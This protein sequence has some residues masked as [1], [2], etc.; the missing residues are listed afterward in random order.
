MTLFQLRPGNLNASYQNVYQHNNENLKERGFIMK[1]KTFI[2]LFAGVILILMFLTAC[3]GGG[4]ET[5]FNANN[6]GSI[7]IKKSEP[8][9]FAKE[10]FNSEL[11]LANHIRIR[12][13]AFHGDIEIEG[14]DD[15]GSII[16]TAQKWVWSDSLEDAKIHLNDLDILVTDQID[17]VLIQTVQP[18][19]R[20]DRKYIVDYHII[21]PSNLETE[22]TLT[23]GDISIID[24]QN[25]LMVDAVNGNVSLSNIFGNAVVDLVNGSIDGTVT[26]PLDGEIRMSAENGNIDLSIPTLT[27][28]KFE[29]SVTVGSIKTSNLEFDDALKTAQSLTGTLGIGEGV[30]DLYSDNGHIGVVGF[31]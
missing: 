28:A 10:T 6:N 7:N 1:A 24:I 19:D 22:V 9:F 14:R 26:L 2:Q 20:Q 30:I 11:Q 8:E 27:S 17:E 15:A 18:E 12:L 31:D 29:A 25:S 5:N 16:V 23:N 13:E 4:I 21:L 3:G